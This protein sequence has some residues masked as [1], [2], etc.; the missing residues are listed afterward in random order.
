MQLFEISAWNDS[1]GGFLHRL[2]DGHPD[3]RCYPYELLLGRDGESVDAFGHDVFRGRFRWPRFEPRASDNAGDLFDI[4]SDAEIR[5]AMRERERSK[6]SPFLI[7]VTEEAWVEV[8]QR[9]WHGL[10]PEE[11]TRPAFLG[12][13]I[14]SLFELLGEDDASKPVLAHCPVAALDFHEMRGDFPDMKMIHVVRSPF[15][16]FRDMSGRHAGLSPE[17]YAWK[18]WVV[19]SHAY[20]LS[21]KYPGALKIVTLDSLLQRRRETLR[22]LCDWL[23]IGLSENVMRPSWRGQVLDE[24]RMGPFGGVPSVAI[25]REHDARCQIEE[26]AALVIS[27]RCEAAWQ[28]IQRDYA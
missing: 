3:L 18:W 8:A 5:S 10:P 27:A 26:T 11:R 12:L 1:G 4:I 9:M 25:D 17:S 15:A 14:E 28:D 24:A 7:D 21:K 22:G 13:Y 19:N 23:G 6:H 20:V 16:G 2:F